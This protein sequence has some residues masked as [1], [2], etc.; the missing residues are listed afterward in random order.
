[1]ERVLTRGTGFYSWQRRLLEEW[2]LAGKVPSAL[3]VP[4]G[5]GKTKIITA[6]L[7]ARALGVALP[8]RLVYVVDRRAVVDQASTEASSLVELFSAAL[9]GAAMSQ[10]Q[11]ESWR[12]NLG[13]PPGEKL[14]VST[15]R[16]Q[17]VDNRLWMDRP[18]GSAIVVGTV[19]MIGSRLLFSGYGVSRG[20]RPVHAA[21]L[22]CDAYLVLDE[23]H[24]VPPF[25]SLL[26]Q[27]AAHTELD[28][29]S[30]PVNCIPQFALTALSATGRTKVDATTFQLS[31]DDLKDPPVEA[32]L[33]AEKGLRMLP[34]VEV[35]QLA[36]TL[37]ERAWELAA[38]NRRVLVFSN[39]RKIAQETETLLSERAKR[40]YG[41]RTVTALL[42]GERRVRERTMQSIANHADGLEKTVVQRFF[43]GAGEPETPLFLV[44]TSA[45][46]VGIDLDADDMVCD[47]VPWERMV[48]RFGRVN[49]RP[50]PGSARIE[51]VPSLSEKDA[52]NPVVVDRL[53]EL[54]APFESPEWA[55][56]GEFHD[57][58]PLALQELKS[59]INPLLER[60]TTPSPFYPE[61]ERATV[62]A[63]ALTSLKEHPGRPLV[64]PWLR[65]W[66]DEPPQTTLVWRRFFPLRRGWSREWNERYGSKAERKAIETDVERFFDAAPPQLIETLQAPADRVSELIKKRIDSWKEPT[67]NEEEAGPSHEPGVVVLTQANDVDQLFTLEKL[68][69][70]KTD[71]LS[72]AIAERTVVLDA[73]LGGLAESGLLDPKEAKPPLAIDSEG[74]FWWSALEIEPS[75]R[76]RSGPREQAR[77]PWR[78]GGFRWIL[79]PDT[80]DSPQLWVELRRDR[81]AVEGDAAVAK[82]AQSL[83][84][85]LSWTRNDAEKIAD[86]LEL[87]LE[88]RVVLALAAGFHDTGKKRD[89]WQDAM[90]AARDG[91]P[92]AKTMGGATPGA[93]AGYRHEFGSLIEALEDPE[94]SAL[95]ADDRELVLHLIASHHGYT[96][97]TVAALDPESAPSVSAS[98]ARAATLRFT[99]LQRVWGPWGLVWWEALLRSADWSA[100][101]RVNTN[102]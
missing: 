9:E 30:A 102:G 79:N 71:Q 51:V 11:R 52:E 23:A 69:T 24:L 84:E 70:M 8:R 91:R 55:S 42:V 73:R 50:C 62:A 75:R 99:R 25:E 80:S 40:T 97:P 12:A 16:G 78:F 26:E 10:E 85:H 90:N 65:G 58:S 17:F 22:G 48:Q 41:D 66:V 94:I 27:V 74:A 38:D 49:R 2:F 89:L 82:R 63:W 93:L 67:G 60:A 34:Q 15:L 77:D 64:A 61:L 33:K 101:R 47:L 45:G 36:A 32:R 3:D 39:S 21:L 31:A 92:F 54:K 43:P 83:G 18:H 53:A 28:R 76:I 96:R 46:E 44:A 4:T 87:P 72:R 57:A 20:M 37:A 7:I 68:R 95:A 88:K 6:W 81:D 35:A 29:T 14:A 59:R 5:L 86:A 56:V 98:V 13:L 100:S 19:D 1:L